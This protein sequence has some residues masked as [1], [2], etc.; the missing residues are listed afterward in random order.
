MKKLFGIVTMLLALGTTLSLSAQQRTRVGGQ[1]IDGKGSSDLHAVQSSY[2]MPYGTLTEEGIKAELDKVLGFLEKNS[3]LGFVD[4]EGNPTTDF[5]DISKVSEARALFGMSSYEWGVT[6]SGLLN[7]AAITGDERYSKYVYDRFNSIGQAFPAAKEFSDKQKAEQA[8]QKSKNNQGKAVPMTFGGRGI[9]RGLTN[10]GALDDCGAMTAAMIKA[11]LVYPEFKSLLKPV[12]EN[13]VDW[14]KN[15][16]HRLADGTLARNRP[17]R[18]SVWLDDMYMGI[19]A[20]AYYGLYSNNNEYYREAAKQILLFKDKMW[21][22]EEKLFRHGWIEAMKYH[23]AFFWG[24]AN[25]WA[26]LTMCDVL[27]VLPENDPDRPAIIALLNEH[28]EGLAKLQSG[29]GFW[30]QLLDRN[31]SYLETSATAIYAYCIAHAINKGWIDGMAFGPVAQ[32]AWEAVT[33]QI[34]DEGAVEGVCVGTG[35]GFDPA[36][37]YFR[38]TSVSARH[39]YGPVLLAGGEMIRLIKNMY[40]RQ[41]DSAILYYNEDPGASGGIFSV[42]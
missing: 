10:P 18:N 22:P 36:F 21:V 27:D 8:K 14:V 34:N 15:G 41:N 30:H 32:L 24:R 26:I 20:L 37:Y 3:A 13:G 23:P 1:S 38:N 5:S 28:V 40:P 33:T 9:L 42:K 25:G 7:I 2:T 19:P 6:Y 29:D 11:T 39:G 31:D 16:E 12:I 35:M 17:D 4:S